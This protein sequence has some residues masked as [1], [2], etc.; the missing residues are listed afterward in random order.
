MGRAPRSQRDEVVSATRRSVMNAVVSVQYPRDRANE[1]QLLTP[2]P[3]QELSVY[4][5]WLLHPSGYPLAPELL[6][7]RKCR[8]RWIRLRISYYIYDTR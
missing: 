8:Q 7:L 3:L 5:G 1:Q 2:P 6:Q 4:G